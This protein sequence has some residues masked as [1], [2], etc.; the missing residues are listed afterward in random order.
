MKIFVRVKVKA[1]EGKV[2]KISE[3]NF[4]V[5]VKEPPEKGKANSAVLKALAGYLNVS[6]SNFR[7]I[8]GFTSR[9]KV[10]EVAKQRQIIL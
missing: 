10:I 1:K 6:Q 3:T 7:I 9:L 2:V 5:S 4:K 8:S